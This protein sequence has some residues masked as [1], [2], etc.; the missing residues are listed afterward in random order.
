MKEKNVLLRIRELDR[1][2][3][4][5]LDYH[6]PSADKPR[7][8]QM[9]ILEYLLDHEGEEVL[10]KDL[11]KYLRMSRAT[12]SDVLAAMEKRDMVRRETGSGDSRTRRVLLNDRARE[13]MKDG[14][15][16]LEELTRAVEEGVSPEEMAVFERALAERTENIEEL[17]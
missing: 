11:E 5:W 13:K 17:Q 6:H 2:I 15:Q 14:R 10:Q 3:T 7:A 16:A 9:L 12:V 1:R 4:G 8:T